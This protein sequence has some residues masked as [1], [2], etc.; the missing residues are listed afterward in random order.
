MAARLFK[1]LA[2][3]ESDNDAEALQALRTAQK[4]LQQEGLSLQQLAEDHERTMGSRDAWARRMHAE[5]AP[6]R[7]EINHYRKTLDRIYSERDALRV[8]LDKLRLH[9][10]VNQG[11][12]VYQRL[13]ERESNVKALTREVRRLKAEVFERDR[14]LR[15]LEKELNTRG[16]GAASAPSAKGVSRGAGKE[17]P[18]LPQRAK[19]TVETRS[20]VAEWV[21][22]CGL[23][24][25]QDET[26]W[27]SVK[28]LFQVFQSAEAPL[29]GGKVLA[30][31]NRFPQRLT[32]SQARFAA[33]LAQV[34]GVE[35]C[36]GGLK[37]NRKGFC[38]V[39]LLD[40]ETLEGRIP[41]GESAQRDPVRSAG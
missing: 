3:L 13:R 36:Y 15:S 1:I 39:S 28:F 38:V 16:A 34:L 31:K 17:P 37:R 10:Q 24:K 40:L 2:L 25:S 21:K 20:V 6:L 4:I 23:K 18:P 22:L 9:L 12:D 7:A 32:V 29:L 5:T 14:A 27:L 35:S 33:A 8:E 11:A 41:Y 30:Q 19:R 26:D